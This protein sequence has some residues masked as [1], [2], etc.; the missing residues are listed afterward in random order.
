MA[1]GWGTFLGKLS[2]FFPGRIEKLKNERQRLIEEHE[3]LLNGR[4]DAKK[5]ARMD[6]IDARLAA[7]S[8]LLSSKVSD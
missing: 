6:R 1:P 2:T 5:A 8:N 4:V 3:Q 7:I